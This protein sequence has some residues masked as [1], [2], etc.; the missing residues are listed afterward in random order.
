MIRE[1]PFPDGLRPALACVNNRPGRTSG[2]P[3]RWM[4]HRPDG[5]FA[6]VSRQL[7]NAVSWQLSALP[8][9]DPGVDGHACGDSF[10]FTPVNKG[11]RIL[12]WLQQ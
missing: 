1:A 9:Q 4:V 8:H 6:P 7:G 2:S 11:S 10:Y 12:E 3:E 5:G